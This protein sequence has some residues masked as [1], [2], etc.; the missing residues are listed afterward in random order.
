VKTVKI[1]TAIE[2]SFP[3][4][5]HPEPNKPF[6]EYPQ[7]WST[8]CTQNYFGSEHD[9]FHYIALL[10]F[11]HNI[12]QNASIQSLADY[13]FFTILSLLNPSV[14]RKQLN[15]QK[16]IF[17]AI[18][19]ASQYNPKMKVIVKTPAHFYSPLIPIIF[20]QHLSPP[21]PLQ[22]TLK[23]N[24]ATQQTYKSCKCKKNTQMQEMQKLQNCKKE[25][26]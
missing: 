8:F 17:S 2:S 16:H 9:D 11:I 10:N 5:Y 18:T 12:T 6:R 19:N 20:A 26:K 1:F 3:N 15:K 4:W 23:H 7:I 21:N 24:T 14:I 25:A 22:N 13:P